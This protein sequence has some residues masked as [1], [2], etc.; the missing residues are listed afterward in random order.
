M[1]QCDVKISLPVR[2]RR[3]MRRHVAMHVQVWLLKGVHVH[4]P[5]GPCGG[6]VWAV[7]MPTEGECT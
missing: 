1:R 5:R 7:R 2:A 3:G 4:P 6:E